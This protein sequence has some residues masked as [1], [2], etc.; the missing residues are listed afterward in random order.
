M[1]TFFADANDLSS[2]LLLLLPRVNLVSGRYFRGYRLY[3]PQ[4]SSDPVEIVPNDLGVSSFALKL[5]Q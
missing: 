1:D 3:G 4:F 5:A 2:S